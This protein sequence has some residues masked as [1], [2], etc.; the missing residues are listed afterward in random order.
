MDVWSPSEDTAGSGRDQSSLTSP[1]CAVSLCPLLL[2]PLAEAGRST[3]LPQHGDGSCCTPA[4]AQL[5]PAQGTGIAAISVLG[6]FET[7]VP[8]AVLSRCSNLHLHILSIIP[9]EKMPSGH[10][11]AP[12]KNS[13]ISL[14]PNTVK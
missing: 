8:I 13:L 5:G 14:L 7:S 3:E 4:S 6:T 9:A 11:C 2:Q 1:L 10:Y 12:C